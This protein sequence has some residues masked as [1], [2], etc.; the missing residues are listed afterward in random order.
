M[1]PQQLWPAGQSQAL[2]QWTDA[3]FVGL[4]TAPVPARHRSASWTVTQQVWLPRSQGPPPQTS[5]GYE[6]QPPPSP[7]PPESS[8]EEGPSPIEPSSDAA[9]LS[10]F[11]DPLSSGGP[12]S[13]DPPD[14]DPPKG[15]VTDPLDPPVATPPPVVITCPTVPMMTPA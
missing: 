1:V 7:F 9:P 6:E 10:S 2:E 11:V 4:H 12:L 3:S 14:E 15:F 5:G 8:P 13:E